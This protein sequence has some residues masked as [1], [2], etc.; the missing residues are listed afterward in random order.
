M[1]YYKTRDSVTIQVWSDESS[2][3]AELEDRFSFM[4]EGFRHMPKFK[5]KLWDGKLRLYSQAKKTLPA[6]LLAEVKKFGEENDYDVIS[7]DKVVPS[8]VVPLG[9]VKE[10]ITSL[11]LAKNSEPITAHDYQIDAVFQAINQKNLL[12]LSPTGSGKSIILA[13]IMR[14]ILTNNSDYKILLIVPTMDLVNQMESDFKDY[15]SINGWDVSQNVQTIMG[16]RSKEITKPV[17]I[18]TWQSISK[19]DGKWFEQFDV[20]FGDEAHLYGA[21]SLSSCMTKMTQ[22]KYRIATTG[23]VKDCTANIMTIVGHFGP[24]YKVATTRELMDKGAVSELKIKC[25]VLGYTPEEVKLLSGQEY[26]DEINWIVTNPR[27]NKFIR[28]LTLSTVGTTIVLFQF[29][30][31]HGRPLYE[32]ILKRAVG[33]KVYFVSGDVSADDREEIRRLA[34]IE[35]GS[36]IVASY[37][38]F[39]TGVNIPSIENVILASPTKSKITNLQSIGRGIRLKEGKEQYIG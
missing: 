23:T 14:W 37:K 16:G 18:S 13:C 22:T 2:I 19:L 5:A 24:I 31:K 11:K 34:S 6:G 33:R 20:V 21:A 36:I 12:L 29:V 35:E 7:K 28:N 30:S 26:K 39:S 10:F 38:T 17:T 4:A 9:V 1:I 32:D 27:R 8:E 3:E 25:L 15:F